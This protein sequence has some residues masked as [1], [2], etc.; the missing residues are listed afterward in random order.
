MPHPL[1][2]SPPASPV[3]TA[4]AVSNEHDCTLVLGRR[5]VLNTLSVGGQELIA[6]LRQDA[7]DQKEPPKAGAPYRFC[8]VTRKALPG[9]RAPCTRV[10]WDNSLV[11]LGSST[12]QGQAGVGV[13]ASH[14]CRVCRV[15]GRSIAGTRR[16]IPPHENENESRGCAQTCGAGRNDGD[17]N[18]HRGTP[19][20]FPHGIHH[21]QNVRRHRM[22]CP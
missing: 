16:R 7:H 14:Q 1:L 17:Q 11:D 8:A 15:P 5:G 10:L 6:W 19:H 21:A 4:P 18:L 12:T 9:S 20:A 22:C 3:G 13:P 2:F